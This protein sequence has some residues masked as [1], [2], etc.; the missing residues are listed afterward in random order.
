MERHGSL[1]MAIGA[2]K[3]FLSFCPAPFAVVI[4]DGGGLDRDDVALV[5]RHLP[6]AR[7]VLAGEATPTIAEALRGMGL[8]RCVRWREELP[9]A[10]KILDMVHYGAG[11]TTLYLDS[12]VL[13]HARPN[14]L[15]ESLTASPF[16]ERF[17]E[18]AHTFYPYSLP[19]ASL[20]EE[21]GRPMVPFFNAGLVVF[22]RSP[23]VS[24][25]RY[26]RW[27]ALPH[28]AAGMV[29][30]T[31][32]AMDATLNGCEALPPWYD[33]GARYARD[34]HSIVT[35]HYLQLRQPHLS[36]DFSRA[37][38]PR[39]RGKTAPDTLSLGIR[40]GGEV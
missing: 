9:Y 5:A 33:A 16:V 23:A 26:E 31:M 35:Q 21:L 36:V 6:G 27:L 22:R 38:A 20:D 15:L 40:V 34:G 24:W 2:I 29:E 13:C 7:V 12:D 14:R 10:R 32:S 37:V 3:S 8:T 19:M 4:H 1:P 18:G 28:T 30:Q 17:N 25:P 39:L 11:A